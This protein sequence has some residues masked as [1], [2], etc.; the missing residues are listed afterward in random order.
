MESRILD[1]VYKLC[2][3]MKTKRADRKRKKVKNGND[4]RSGQR[5]LE[6]EIMLEKLSYS[7]LDHLLRKSCLLGVIRGKT[8]DV[9]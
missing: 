1:F 9:N 3:Y 2:R 6:S 4:R 5:K 7:P 8:F